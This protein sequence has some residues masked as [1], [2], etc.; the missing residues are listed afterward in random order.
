M[1]YKVDFNI[2]VAYPKG[3]ISRK[4]GSVEVDAEGEM[5]IEEMKSDNELKMVIFNDMQ[6]QIKTGKIFNV[7][8]TTIQQH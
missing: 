5:P 8:I 7:E 3:R 2:D 1:K 4:N 6:P